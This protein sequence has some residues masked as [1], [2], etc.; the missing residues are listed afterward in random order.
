MGKAIPILLLLVLIFP[1]GVFAKVGVG[2]GTGEI[3]L[4]TPLKAGGVHTL[5]SLTISNT[6]DE[7]GNYKVGIAFH[8][9][10]KELRPTLEWFSFNPSP[11]LLEAGQSQRVEIKLAIPLRAEPGDYFVY[12]ESS[13]FTKE[14]HVTKV[15]LAVGTRLFFTIVPSN[16]WQAVIWYVSS[17]WKMYSPWTWVVLGMVL[18]AIVI[19]L[20]RKRFAFQIGIKKK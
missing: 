6:G 17:R 9:E 13:S 15:G 5:P 14:E 11:F 20:F 4:I 18:A 12:L 8:A 7:P 19:V 2:V 10:R 1:L 16:T 3:R